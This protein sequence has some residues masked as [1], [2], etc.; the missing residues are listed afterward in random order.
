MV[1][2]LQIKNPFLLI[3]I[4]QILA[5]KLHNKTKIQRFRM[6]EL[7]RD[8]L[9]SCNFLTARIPQLAKA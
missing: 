9:S 1:R 3:K 4:A 8:Q 6:Q 2:I 5:K 7:S